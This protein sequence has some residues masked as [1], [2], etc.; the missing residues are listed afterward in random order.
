MP[1]TH[2]EDPSTT[3]TVEVVVRRNDVEIHRELCESAEEAAAVVAHWEEERGVECEVLDLSA[4]VDPEAAEVDWVEA[5]A[6]YPIADPD[7]DP[8]PT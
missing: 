5:G 4:P 2:P 6:D 3:P 1:R 7:P 8:D